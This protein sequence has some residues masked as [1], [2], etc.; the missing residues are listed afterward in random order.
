MKKTEVDDYIVLPVVHVYKFL[1]HR[2]Y[3]KLD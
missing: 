2:V 3:R 1:V